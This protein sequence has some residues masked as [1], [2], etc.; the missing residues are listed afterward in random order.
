MKVLHVISYTLASGQANSDALVHLQQL[1]AH[2]PNH[3]VLLFCDLPDAPCRIM[4]DERPLMNSLLHGISAMHNSQEPEVLL[5][6]RSRVWDDAARMYLGSS[7]PLSCRA[8]IAQL[9][10]HEQ[11]QISFEAASVSPSSLKGS[12]D[13]VLFSDM[14]LTC[15]P[16]VPLRMAAYLAG[17]SIRAAGADVL[18]H[19]EHPRSAL[20]L[21]CARS[22]LSLSPVQAMQK[23][24]LMQQRRIS[25]DQ[26]VMYTSQAL[27]SL[28]E[29]QSVPAAPSCA[30]QC[31]YAPTVQSLFLRYR[32][33]CREHLFP[34]AC[35][36]LL[37]FA[38]LAA[39]AVSG[40]PLWAAAAVLPELWALFHP[41]AW[42][43]VLLR[44]AL[45]PLTTLHALDLLLC[46][47]LARSP[48]LRLRVPVRLFSP[49]VCLFAALALFIAALISVDA[50]VSVLPFV[51]LWLCMPVLYPVLD[52]PDD[53][54]CRPRPAPITSGI[55]SP[56][57]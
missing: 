37:Q 17:E 38:A 31:R 26:P 8:A 50:L 54:G 47:L 35:V 30:F 23:C 57:P 28:D 27:A 51:L 42:P 12:F 36:P 40:L 1:H 16:D 53:G 21:L 25:C 46:R 9:L 19:H 41:S 3:A 34:H 4:P 11:A 10:V 15:S 20:S 7:Q 32:S 48:L 52:Q 18:P 13:A 55:S 49:L 14:S 24:R 2:C 33:L 43:G 44:T 5:L 29:I 39:G 56:N 22:P 45:L 6:V